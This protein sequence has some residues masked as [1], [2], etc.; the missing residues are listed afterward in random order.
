MPYRR[1]DASKMELEKIPNVILFF[2]QGEPRLTRTPTNDFFHVH[3]CAFGVENGCHAVKQVCSSCGRIALT[4][5]SY[6]FLE[7][8]RLERRRLPQRGMM[9]SMKCVARRVSTVGILD[10]CKSDRGEIVE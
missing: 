5:R 1:G 8:R 4:F 2:A 10:S 7:R 3:L 6:E 9:R